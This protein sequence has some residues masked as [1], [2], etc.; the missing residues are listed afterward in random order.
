[1]FATARQPTTDAVR[2]RAFAHHPDRWNK[3]GAHRA[4]RLQGGGCTHVGLR[5]AH[6]EDQ[7]I[8]RPDIGLFAVC[9]GVGGH[10]AG[11][12]A[13]LLAAE[14]IG[15]LADR[16]AQATGVERQL[17]YAIEDVNSVIFR[18]GR[19]DPAR[20]GMATTIA[21]LWIDHGRAVIAHVGD[22]RVYRL[23][24][25][26]LDQLTLDHSLVGDGVR[27]GLL[28]PQQADLQP[29][30]SI[31]TRCLGSRDDVDVEV[32]ATPVEPGDRFIL[33]SDGLSDLVPKAQLR[34]IAKVNPS[35]AEATRQ[36]VLA[37]LDAGGYDNIT[38][39]VVDVP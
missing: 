7:W 15:A 28:T 4:R 39:V 18:E 34:R 10:A 17:R 31:I 29:P 33:C 13:S 22:S 35:G 30:S 16:A 3:G 1:M 19:A 6:N 21:A 26:S 8:A 32:S 9:D 11:E 37:A 2:P 27:L 24:D 5:R 20:T 12:V 38:V 25:G 23:R 14:H 36:L